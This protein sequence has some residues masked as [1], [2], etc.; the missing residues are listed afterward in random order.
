MRGMLRGLLDAGFGLVPDQNGGFGVVCAQLLGGRIALKE[1]KSG[2]LAHSQVSHRRLIGAGIR[3]STVATWP[4]QR[5]DGAA[6]LKNR[7]IIGTKTW[8]CKAPGT[9]I[10][11]RDSDRSNGVAKVSLIKGCTL[12]NFPPTETS[13]I[14]QRRGC[15]SGLLACGAHCGL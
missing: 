3:G 8:D 13:C 12:C 1:K 7:R 9:V 11:N 6:R 4:W 5:K 2:D 15:L 10:R 14:T